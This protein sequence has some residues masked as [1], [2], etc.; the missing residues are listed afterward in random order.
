MQVFSRIL[1][2]FA[3]SMTKF[4]VEV[5]EILSR[6]VEI[7]ADS[8]KDAVETARQMYRNCDLVL[9]DS[10]YIETKISVKR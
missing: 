7:E 6:I 3:Q 4:R 5:M 1:C 9:D 2:Y 10:D 8:A